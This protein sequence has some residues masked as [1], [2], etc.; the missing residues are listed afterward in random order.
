[1]KLLLQSVRYI[2]ACMI[3]HHWLDKFHSKVDKSNSNVEAFV[4]IFGFQL[5]LLFSSFFLF[6]LRHDLPSH[7]F[8]FC[9][10]GY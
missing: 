1:M 5:S 9:R 10:V 8:E 7:L 6:T 2:E 3:S 4:D